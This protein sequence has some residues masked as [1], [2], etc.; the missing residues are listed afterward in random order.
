[1]LCG[2]HNRNSPRVQLNVWQ[3]NQV[4]IAGIS[5]KAPDTS[6]NTDS[7]NLSQSTFVT[8]DGANLHSGQHSLDIPR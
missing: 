3:C 2:G 4:T 7:I 6:P 8:I 1:M 5:T